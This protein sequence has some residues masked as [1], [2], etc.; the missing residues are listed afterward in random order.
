MTNLDRWRYYLKDITSPDHFID[1]G[2][3]FLIAAA[4]QR[5]VWCGGEE[6]PLFANM[7]VML[8]GPPGVGKG[9]VLGPVRS[10]LS[11]HIVKRKLPA[12]EEAKAQTQGI[13]P[14]DFQAALAGMLD[15]MA[16]MQNLRNGQ[17]GPRQI[18]DSLVFPVG[19]DAT[20]F[21][22]LV[23]FNG[24]NPRYLVDQKPTRVLAP[25]GRYMHNSIC[26]ILPEMSTLFRRE[27][28][29]VVRYLLTTYDC[30][31]FEYR[32]K[33]QGNDLLKNTCTSLIAG[34]VSDFLMEGKAK[35]LLHEG[36]FGRTV[37]IYE[38][39]PRRYAFRIPDFN[40]EQLECKKHILDHLLALSKAFGQVSFDP[41]ADEFLHTYFTK[42]LPNERINTDPKL[43]SYYARKN[44]TT[45]KLAMAHH[46]A[47][48]TTDF[49]I[50]L[51]TVK[52][53]LAQLEAIEPKMSKALSLVGSNEFSTICGEVER[54][55]F[56]HP[57]QSF[58][59]I[60]AKFPMKENELLDVVRYLQT[61]GKIGVEK[62]TTTLINNKPKVVYVPLNAPR[63][64]D[65]DV[66]E[67]QIRNEKMLAVGNQMQALREKAKE[68]GLL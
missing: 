43:D 7:Y 55:L 48:Q 57:R 52:K 35:G 15:G 64:S 50:R 27:A 2:F 68:L 22:D 12:K 45:Q 53:V 6:M 54:W 67:M 46:F 51:P 49:V 31:P 13:S 23:R 36:F 63:A 3:Y 28:E 56:S 37:I 8:V 30:G 4:L 41:E 38:E 29:Q 32:T 42:I 20:S 9:L 26:F 62:D 47:D 16:A 61:V 39:V 17:R 65:R 66:L 5:R 59:D 19:A 18:E 40:D 44:I 14:D 1:F 58:R 10:F 21:E 34:T 60:W 24:S 25:K 11:H 33:T